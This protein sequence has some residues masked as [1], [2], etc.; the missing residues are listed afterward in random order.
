[1][2]RRKT[3][4]QDAAKAA[5][6][7]DPV[8]VETDTGPGDTDPAPD[9]RPTQCASARRLSRNLPRLASSASTCLRTRVGSPGRPKARELAW[10]R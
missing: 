5:A 1:M 3:D 2:T 10:G 9:P 6:A 7:A 4:L 8:E